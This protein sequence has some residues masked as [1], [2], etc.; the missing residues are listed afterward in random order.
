MMS[1]E[2]LLED[3]GS[4]DRPSSSTIPSRFRPTPFRW[5]DPATIPR[6]QFVFGTHLIRGFVALTVAPGGVG[7]SSLA[8]GEAVSMASGENLLGVRPGRPLR[9]WYVNLEDPREEIE[10]RVAAVCLHFEIDPA[11]LKDRPF[12]DGRE[13]EVLIAEQARAGFRIAAPV[14]EALVLALRA[15]QFDALI[16]DPFVSTHRVTENDNTAIDAV[17]KTFGRIAGKAN[18][19]VELI[20]HVRKTGGAEIS[21]ED[22]RGASA[23]IAAARSVRVLN[24]MTKDEAVASGVGEER[25]FY[26][27]ADIGKAN[28]TPPSIKAT[29]FKMRSVSLGNGPPGMAYDGGDPVGVVTPWQWPEAFDGVTVANLRAAQARVATGLWRESAQ[30]RDW[31]GIPIAEALGLDVGNKAHV[32]KIKTL[33]MTWISNGMFVV[34]KGKDDKRNLRQFVEVGEPAHE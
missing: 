2:Q 22:G 17:A 1:P 12:F 25:R 4:F 10:R 7:K 29:W 28:L 16:L 3:L 24:P 15:G 13:T 20:H 9:V 33:L 21:A 18:C 5:R 34:V 32:A 23:L 19:A 30:S 31:V 26:F 6:R 11:S 27:R 14:E 8:I